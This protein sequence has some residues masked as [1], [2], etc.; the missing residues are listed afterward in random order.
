[1]EK[2]PTTDIETETI[3]EEIASVYRVLTF[4]SAVAP[5]KVGVFPLMPKDGLVEIAQEINTKFKENNIQ[6]FYDDSGSIGRRYARMDEVGTPFCITVDYDTK[7]DNAVT[8]RDRD[9]H[10]QARVKIAELA[11]ILEELIMG[12]KLFNDL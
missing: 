10:S 5:I 4:P 6:S 11:K 3:G 2:E 12:K 7:N 1:V 9:S 8:I